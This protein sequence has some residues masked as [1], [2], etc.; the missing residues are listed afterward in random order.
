MPVHERGYTHWQPTGLRADPAWWVIARRG[1]SG[2]LRQRWTMILLFVAMTPAV[3]RG[4][5]IF[6]KA[7]A[8][9]M[10]DLVVGSEWASIT[11]GGFLAFVETQRFFIFLITMI[12][13]AG[14]IARDRRENGLAL[15]FS[16]PLG[17]GD[18]LLGK[19][20]I[21]LGGYLAV[22]LFPVLVLCLFAYLIDPGAVGLEILLLTPLRL[23]VFCTLAGASLSLVLLA[24]SSLATRTVLVVV[25]W[26]VVIVGGEMVGNIGQALGLDSLQFANVLGHWHNAGS[27]LLGTD[28]RLP[29]S[30][31]ASLVFC[32]LA[33]VGALAILR[34][35][36]RPVEVVS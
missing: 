13:G 32:A 21:I 12:L 20:L 31:W 1:L 6:I 9:E 29:I 22:T 16:R 23:T 27:L 2:P 25:W 18:Y 34:A 11:A 28:P 30:P 17:L 14:L 7:R 26:A 5:T 19:G 3:V 24:L 15:Y 4:V 36:I 8:G 10:L 35:R 33:V